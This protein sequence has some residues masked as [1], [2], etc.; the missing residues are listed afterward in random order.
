VDW[1]RQVLGL[2]YLDRLDRFGGHSVARC[3]TNYNHV[4]ADLTRV[5]KARLNHMGWRYAPVA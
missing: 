5:Q 4:G 2:R 1:T 3:T